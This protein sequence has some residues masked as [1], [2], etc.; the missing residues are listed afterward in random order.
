MPSPL[1]L[2]TSKINDHNLKLKLEEN[3]SVPGLKAIHP[4]C[5]L[6][7]HMSI[8]SVVLTVAKATVP[9]W[10]IRL[11]LSNCGPEYL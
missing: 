8:M 1:R 9:F 6:R 10:A 11:I 5:S 4:S 2:P 7:L 3:G